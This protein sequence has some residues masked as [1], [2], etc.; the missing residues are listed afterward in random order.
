LIRILD[1]LIWVTC[2]MGDGAP[3]S[4]PL[5]IEWSTQKGGKLIIGSTGKE[6][7]DDD[8]NVVHEGEMWSKVLEPGPSW[9]VTHVDTRPQYKGLRA[10]AK[11]PQG[12]GYM[13]FESGRWSSEHK[14]WM[15][16]PRS[17]Y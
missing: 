15:F 10:A 5:K 13:I 17:E 4:K 9:A 2:R 16:A 1:V 7:T 6:R 3:G 8:G 12:S 11:C 14:M